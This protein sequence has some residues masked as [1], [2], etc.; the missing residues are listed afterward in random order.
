MSDRR[1]HTGPT[2]WA[3]ARWAAFGAAVTALVVGAILAVSAFLRQPLSIQAA[4]AG[5]V[6]MFVGIVTLGVAVVGMLV[7]RRRRQEP[8]RPALTGTAGA[9]RPRGSARKLE[10]L[11]PIGEA[12]A[13]ALALGVHPARPHPDALA[14][15]STIL[16]KH[17]PRDV[18]PEVR[19]WMR[20]A[21][22]HGGFLLVVG[23]PCVGKT[24]LLYDAATEELDD[25]VVLA[26][27]L[28]DG[29]AVNALANPRMRLPKLVVW[30]DELHRFLAGPY[31]G[32]GGTPLVAKTIRYLLDARAPVVLL[33]TLWPAHAAELR[34][35]DQDP[36]TGT[37]RHRHPEAADVLD[38]D[39][40]RR[41]ITVHPFSPTERYAAE[42]RSILDPC[43]AS[44]VADPDYNVT[45][46][47]AGAPELIRRYQQATEE[48]RAVL[49]AAVDANRLGVRAPLSERLL[50]AASRTYLTT[51]HPGQDWFSTTLLELTKDERSTAPLIRIPSADR[52]ST[53]G[54]TVSNFLLQHAA[55]ERRSARVSDACW[56]ALVEHV[57]NA[58]DLRRLAK[59][60]ADRLLLRQAERIYRRL[61]ATDW[62]DEDGKLA[63]L[64]L[65]Q[66]RAGDLRAAIDDR[67][68]AQGALDDTVDSLVSHGCLD[69]AMNRLQTRVE[70]GDR[71]AA[72]ELIRLLDVC[73]AKGVREFIRRRRTRDDHSQLDE[74]RQQ[75]ACGDE[76]ALRQLSIAIDHGIGYTAATSDMLAELAGLD[77]LVEAFGQHWLRAKADHGSEVAAAR[78]TRHLAD[79]G[80]LDELRAEVDAGTALAAERYLDC[81]SRGTE[82]ERRDAAAIRRYGLHT[83][84]SIAQR[85][86]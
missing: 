79:R 45:E 24:R 81:L 74:L 49:H 43:L 54:Y 38:A 63:D 37:R 21:R 26:P 39:R 64:Y 69:C 22:A 11:P 71:T 5:V 4:V 30:L 15:A 29:A 72:T 7:Q 86:W 31:L 13:D 1:M 10:P 57:D 46:A 50:L 8:G 19:A 84:G 52:Q 23:D 20:E 82:T 16:P 18:E 44:A 68:E 59:A 61:A 34:G 6:S 40:R 47:L 60:A 41:E 32:P 51:V 77:S 83:D 67:T 36:R 75:L 25:F 76:L 66:D 14:D 48:Q 73:A 78:L 27:D 35:T 9:D 42:Q 28:G 53:V 2:G 58:D 17:V 70:A 12:P 56:T 33:G 55:K 80:A 65:S 85:W 3:R 62:V